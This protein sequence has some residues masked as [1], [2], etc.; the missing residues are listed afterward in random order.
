MNALEL[1][2]HQWNSDTIMK[3]VRLLGGSSTIRQKSA[4]IDFVCDKLLDPD[5]L[6][7]IWQGLDPVAQRAISN[8]Y[9]N[10]GVFDAQAFVA[11]YGELPPRPESERGYYG[12]YFREPILFDLFVLDAGK[13]PA[14]LLPLLTD[15]VLPVDRFQL[16][17]TAEL[18]AAIKIWEEAQ[19]LTVAETELSGRTDLLTY[20]QMVD[21]GQVSWGRSN[22]L[23]TAAS[24]RKVLANLMDGDFHPEPEKITGRTVIRPFGLDV[25]TRE[26][27]LVTRTGKLTAAGRTYLQ[28]Q[29]TDT[30]L[31]AFEKW[32]EAGRFDEL[33]RITQLNGQNS[34]QT[35]L[36]PPAERREKVVEALSWCPAHTWI[37][38]P[39]FYRAV[40]VWQFDFEVE[41]TEWSNLHAGPY[42]SYGD[43]TATDYW[44]IAKGLYINAIVME[45]LGAIGAVDLAYLST[46]YTTLSTEAHY[47]DEL[48]SLH[49]GLRYFRINNWGAFLLGQADAYE[50]AAPRKKDLFVVDAARQVQLLAELLP[51]EALQL[52]AMATKVGPQAYQLDQ[53]KLLTAVESG[54]PFAQLTAFLAANNR[55]ELPT[56]V[57]D[58]L[59]QLED[60]IGLFK[61]G[62][63]AVVIKLRHVDLRQVIDSDPELSGLCKPLDDKTVVV[64]SGS[65]T[66]A[67]NRLKALGYLLR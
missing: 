27:G 53:E 36:T 10:D 13:I 43:M 9:H 33:S 22:G 6:R 31:S 18:P 62:S 47:T 58:W 60:Q 4:R 15:L 63:D 49:E 54:V 23:L 29:D 28:T 64:M 32:A 34:R 67:R 44:L 7:Q 66:R 41:K 50:P 35:H 51:N 2:L 48:Y 42:K 5:S 65:L 39:N 19:A 56:A 11:Q 45:Y 52:D 12:Y 40:M 1:A 38:V 46:D 14:D 3:Y 17:G 37:A 16:E 57:T 8:A 26:A 25:F 21:Q 20:L 59:T 24:V 55:G 61:Q 30:F